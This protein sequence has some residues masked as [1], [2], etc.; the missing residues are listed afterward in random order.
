[1]QKATLSGSV[2]DNQ[3]NLRQAIELLFAPEKARPGQ[4]SP[5]LDF[6]TAKTI[7]KDHG[8]LKS[9]P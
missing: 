7:N 8:R 6:Q 1:M 2:K 3:R 5:A 4:G 9:V